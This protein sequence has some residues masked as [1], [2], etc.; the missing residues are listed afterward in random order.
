MVNYLRKANGKTESGRGK[1]AQ[2]VSLRC[3]LYIRIP[4]FLSF[5]RESQ[6]TDQY[7]VCGPDSSVQLEKS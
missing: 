6:P 4:L 5:D 2:K 3:S 7:F 1:I